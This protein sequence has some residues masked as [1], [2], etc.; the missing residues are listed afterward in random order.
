MLEILSVFGTPS[1]K[2]L[3]L[4]SISLI[5]LSAEAQPTFSFIL[6]AVDSPT[7]TPYFLLKYDTMDSLNLSPPVLRELEKTTPFKARIAI[8]VVPPP[9]STTIDPEA[10]STGSPAPIAAAIGS[11]INLTSLAPA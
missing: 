1:A 4:T 9:I 10:S 6:S 3:P 7:K 5:S 2:F 11:S 8:S